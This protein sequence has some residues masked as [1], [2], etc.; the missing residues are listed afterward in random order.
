MAATIVVEATKLA[1]GTIA[2]A[3]PS[4]RVTVAT[5]PGSPA[6]AVHGAQID[7]AA[8]EAQIRALP[9]QGRSSMLKDPPGRERLELDTIAGPTLRALGPD[10]APATLRAVQTILGAR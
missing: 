8:V 4:A 6:A 7:P 10:G 9:G 3:F 2:Q 5:P 1:D